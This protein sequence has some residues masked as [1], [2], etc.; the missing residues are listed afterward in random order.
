MT[1][2]NCL[3]VGLSSEAI[4]RRLKSGV[5]IRVYRD[6]YRFAAAPASWHQ[7][8]LAPCLRKCGFVW[9]FRRTAGAFWQLDGCEDRIVEVLA[10]CRLE[11]VDSVQ[12]QRVA[13][14][15]KRH[16]TV[17]SNIPVT[18]VHRTL[19]DLGSV[20]SPHAVEMALECALRR[21][22]TSVDP[23]VAHDR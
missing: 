3:S 10:T 13:Y 14:M 9:A 21:R 11:F 16:V 23:A 1:R 12:M 19:A 7:T 5:L 17:V 8:V 6:V 22:I 18:M 20:A 15:P 2:A 4:A